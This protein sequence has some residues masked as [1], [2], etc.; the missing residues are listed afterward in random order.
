METQDDD[1]D[2]NNDGLDLY[3]AFYI[4]TQSTL[5]SKG[6]THLI[7]HMFSTHLGDAWQPFCARTLIIQQLAWWGVIYAN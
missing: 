1:D 6:E 4:G 3:S 7:H 2:N 5:H